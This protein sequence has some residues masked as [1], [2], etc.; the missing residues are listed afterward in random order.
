MER[1]AQ[2]GLLYYRSGLTDKAHELLESAIMGSPNNPN[3]YFSLFDI[4]MEKLEYKKAADLAD[5]LI[6]N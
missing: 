6:T 2:L 5:K 4:Y 1:R 3:Y